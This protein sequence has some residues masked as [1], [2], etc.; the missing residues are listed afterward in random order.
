MRVRSVSVVINTL[1]R[2]ERLRRTLL[3]LC[4]QT[5]TRFEVLVVNGPS[6]DGTKEMLAALGPRARILKCPRASLGLS[7]N[8][9]ARAAAGEIVAF[10]DDDAIPSPDWLE[11]LLAPYSDPRVSGVGGPVF[12]V[13]LDR[14]AWKLCV[15][16][17]LGVPDPDAPGPI[18]RYAFPGSDPVA[19]L[20]GCNMSYRR[21]AIRT[22]DGFNSLLIYNYDDVEICMRLTDAGARLHLVDEVL[23]RHD[24]APNSAR[25]EALRIR[26]PYPALFCRAI[27]ALQADTAGVRREAIETAIATAADQ[28]N[29][30][31]DEM[32]KD[33]LLDQKAQFD[34]RAAVKRAVADGLHEGMKPRMGADLGPPDPTAFLSYV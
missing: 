31:T 34:F 14:V 18:S 19:Y 9:G 4:E 17:R 1:N 8:I 5:H 20:P 3:A 10:I 25:D 30:S 15:C 24:R 7:R 27:F 32:V 26:D 11:R 12:D 33:G 2:C 21:E 28:L 23:V 13:P 6:T 16:T 29:G 22:T